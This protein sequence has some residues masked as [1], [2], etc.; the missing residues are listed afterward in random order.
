MGSAKRSNKEGQDKDA[1]KKGRTALDERLA[2]LKAAHEA[3]QRHKKD[4]DQ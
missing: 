4:K 2:T 3:I 1:E